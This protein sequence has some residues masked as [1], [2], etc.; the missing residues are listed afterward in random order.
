MHGFDK[1]A[2]ATIKTRIGIADLVGRHVDLR[3]A[4]ARLVG[5]CPFHN[6]TKGSFSVNEDE[7]FFHCFGCK[8]SGDVITF[9]QKINGLDFPEAVRQ[10]AVEAGVQLEEQKPES[11]EDR[12]RRDAK[13]LCFSLNDLA[14]EFYRDA[15]AGPEGAECRDY[16]A[17]R[18][19]T[20]EVVAAFSLGWAP[21]SFDG[22]RGLLAA[23]RMN[24]DAAVAAGLLAK[25]ERGRVYDRFRA[26]LMFPI[27]S[28]ADRVVAF[29]G[30]TVLP[31]DDEAPKYIN[32]P[33][34]PVYTKGEHLFGLNLARKRIVVSK[35]ALLTEGYMDVISL[36]Q[37]GFADACGVLGTA[38]TPA[39]VKRLSG[40]ASKV[41]LLFD[42]DEPGRKAAARAVEMLASGGL[43]SRVALFPEGEDVDSLL[44]KN[45]P[46]ALNAVLDAAPDGFDFLCRR[47]LDTGSP[48]E[49]V[50][51]AKNFLNRLD[52]PELLSFWLPRL[53]RGLSLSEEALKGEIGFGRGPKVVEGPWIKDRKAVGSD[54]FAEGPRALL[55]THAVCFPEDVDRLDAA[56][57]Y[58]FLETDAQRAFWDKLVLAGQNRDGLGL[59]E[60]ETAFYAK[61]RFD[62]DA[63]DPEREEALE[64]M[65]GLFE[66][67]GL[68]AKTAPIRKSV[69]D[70]ENDFDAVLERL[71][72][73]RDLTLDPADL[74]LH[75]V[76]AQAHSHRTVNGP[77]SPEQPHGKR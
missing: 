14:V 65:L 21:D 77:Q 3:R 11:A 19:L 38:L 22:L 63:L 39:Q 45:G 46:E 36:H 25:N 76:E 23:R 73:F 5:R 75:P 28:Q 70:P 51:F 72:R 52:K 4:G 54:V 24:L 66:R 34:S 16:L 56:G 12:A 42:G 41:D 44:Q 27:K 15:L 18:G 47:L 69:A 7:G 26:R 13:S 8:A 37:F 55:F 1:N 2:L 43:A 71:K 67:N 58:A 20:A 6:E 35:R 64:N 50:E 61:A 49:V 30:R 33:E 53:A 74:V 57:A 29:G 48:K 62:K 17:K 59:D 9:H 32:S 10:L 31:K 40:F 68:V 60:T